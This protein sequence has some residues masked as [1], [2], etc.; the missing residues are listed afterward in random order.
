MFDLKKA[1]KDWRKSLEKN[2]A[3]EDGYKEELECHLRD[4][5]E[6]LKNLGRSEKKAFEEAVRAIG[7]AEAI[8]AEYY[9]T[10]TRHLNGQAP[11]R[12][13]RWLPPLISNYLKIGLRKIKRQKTYSLINMAGLAVGLAC[14]AV[15]ILYV[16]G[17]LSY[18][19][20]HKDADRIYR[21][22]T[23]MINT[24]GEFRFTT[25]PGPL[26]PEL[27]ASYPQ[28]ELA[29]RLVPPFENADHVLV[30]QGEKRFFEKRV[31]FADNEIFQLFSIPF[32]RGNPQTALIHPNTVVIT[33]EMAEKYFGEEAPMGKMLRIEID[34]DTGNT[35]LQDYEVQGVLKNAP[36]NTH[37][38]YD[39]FLSMET[40]RNNQPLFEENWT[41]FHAKYTYV[42]LAAGTNA[43]E[44]EKRIEREAQ[45]F[46]K[47]RKM[48]LYEFFLQSVTQ[49]H[50]HS[51]YQ[52][53]IDPPGN[54][55]Y[56]TIYSII[57]LLILL[58][59]CMNFINLSAA[60]STTRTREVGLRKVIGAL[61]RQLVAQFLGESFL[62]TFLALILAAGLIFFLL[63]PFNRM[64]GTALTLSGLT[65]PLVLLSL[66]GLLLF[67]AIGAG[68]YP[69]FILTNFSPISVIQGKWASV[70]RGARVQKILVIGQ[71]A[72]S[73]FLVIC[74]LIV[75][76]QLHFMK[77]RAL[78]IDL[79]QKIV[80]RVKSNLN[81][82]RRDYEAVKNDFLQHPSITGATVSSSVPG[83]KTTGGYYLT[84]KAE[85][86]NNAA[87]LKILTVD[88]DF[89]PEY[90]IKM[91]AGRAF[92]KS[93]GNDENSAYVINLAG[94]KELGLASPE[95]ALG[96][97][98]MAHYHRLTKTI[99][100]VTENF[101]YRGMQE[102]VEPLILDIENSL[103]NT[104][105]LSIR[106]ENMNQLM[107]FI[108]DKWDKHFPGVP[109]EYTFL[110]ESFAREYRYEE[111]TG[112]LLGIITTLGFFIACL[113]L[114]GLASFIA[115]FRKKE[116]GIRKVLGAS[117]SQIVGMLSKRFVLLTM[118]SVIVASPLAWYAMNRWLQDFAYRINI[119]PL[120]FLLA[121]GGALAIAL[122]TVGLQGF[123]AAISNPAHSLRNE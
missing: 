34:Y 76:K 80:L 92:Q 44:F 106:I 117:T 94:V 25:S 67:V 102:I 66:L 50:M 89:I 3:L 15:I 41:D 27:K 69:A 113:G 22:S 57:A 116:I 87:R 48:E 88:Y 82:F 52:R 30:T 122:A 112:K 65:Q 107:S 38:K 18:D 56:V 119:K 91:A 118:F 96:K 46:L 35:E 28:V 62:I 78:G 72:I 83:E 6:Y 24:V 100:G 75:F 70:S 73:V 14:C 95:E 81:H 43:A 21:V 51:H 64:A 29:V 86:F 74:T 114:F 4:K 54:W 111:Q 97:R 40:M 5:I 108:K 115:Q 60:L 104:I 2:E 84:S 9:K 98:F 8:G 77:G 93:F 47:H 105:T 121:A 59:G 101:H 16:T 42:K 85:D 32:I 7:E 49:I 39:M 13:S 61:R 1:I 71:F 110:D 53:E 20:Y 23:H 103:F 31:W 26:G 55:T 123:R 58:I 68:S 10:N 11:W 12:K 45:I 19:Q 109:F 36:A 33:E 90:D 79:E 17:E 99:V 37:L 120:I 63:I